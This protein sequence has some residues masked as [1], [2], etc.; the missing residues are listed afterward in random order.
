M[1]YLMS[2]ER[3]S[4]SEVQIKL[5]VKRAH[6]DQSLDWNSLARVQLNKCKFNFTAE[7]LPPGTST[8]PAI[9]SIPF[10][11]T[12]IVRGP[13]PYFDQIVSFKADVDSIIEFRLSVRD[14][15]RDEGTEVGY[16]RFT[17]RSVAATN[18]NQ[19][20]N[21]AFSQPIKSLPWLHNSTISSS[22]SLGSIDLSISVPIRELSSALLAQ[23]LSRSISRI[24]ANSVNGRHTSG[25]QS[26]STSGITVRS[27]SADRTMNNHLVDS[28]GGVG[29]TLNPSANHSN[30]NNTENADDSSL[31]PGW[32]VKYTS[33]GR[34]YYVDHLTKTTTWCKPTPLPPGWERR[35]DNVGR[36]YYIDHNTRTTTWLCPN[37]TLLNTVQNYQ[38]MTASRNGIMQQRMNERYAN[39]VWNLGESEPLDASSRTNTTTGG[40]MDP[41]GPLPANWERRVDISGRSYFVNHVSRISQWEDPRIQGHP[42]P[43]GWEIRYTTEGFPFFVDHNTKT[44]TFNDPRRKDASGNIEQAWSF[45]NKVA[46]FHYLC[47][48]NLVTKNVKVVVSRSNLLVDSFEQIMRLKPHELRCRLFISFTGEEGLDYGGL[49]REWFFKLSTELLNPMYCLFEYAGGNNY[50]LQINPASSVNPEHLEYF[51][52]VGR[53]IALALY[54]SRFIDN[55]FTLPFYKRM[56]NK[57]IT[58]ADIETVDVEYYNSLKFIQENNIDECGLDVYFAMD[59]EV[60]GELRTHELKPG[61]RDTLL[62]DAN[63]AEYI[64]LMVNWRFSRGVEDQTNAFLTGFED[65]F[66]LQWLQYFDERELEVLLCGMQQIDVDDWQSHTTYKKYD[67]RSPQVLWFWKFVRSLTQQRRIRLLQFVTGTCR[68]PVGGFKNLMGNN[69]PQ[70]FCIEYIGKDSWLPRSHTC[71]NRLD[72]PPYRSYEQ[73]AEKLS[74]AIDETEGFGQE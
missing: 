5:V 35:R 10:Y 65:V 44:S 24:T 66:P 3:G 14:S 60:L 31:P 41:L 25:S 55:G 36:V 11:V 18:G 46:S 9:N 26:E 43:P 23:H 58:L 53:F 49:S 68:V 13:R 8:V 74:Y 32:E 54:H 12:P 6:L 17:V 57:N 7:V 34:I 52:F 39:A 67:A 45:E 30:N 62:T 1:F 63:K 50:A 56:L 42:L 2:S 51:R 4:L 64:D 19:L 15:K 22:S 72:L 29:P 69:G 28:G 38:Q 27:P 37:P 71:F 47:H 21:L 59:Y 33:E 61:G 48:S 16:G 40:V 73:L 20:S 70:P